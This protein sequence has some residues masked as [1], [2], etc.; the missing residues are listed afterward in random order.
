MNSGTFNMVEM[1]LADFQVAV[2]F[3]SYP[4]PN[5]PFYCG[6]FSAVHGPC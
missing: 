4:L 1:P 3:N 2:L 6:R 5:R